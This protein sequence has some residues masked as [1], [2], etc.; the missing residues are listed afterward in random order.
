[1]LFLDFIR[2]VTIGELQAV[3]RE[4][5]LAPA[6]ARSASDVGASR[7]NE[8]EFFFTEIAHYLYAGDTALHMAAAA[9]RRDV[10]ELLIAHDAD[11]RAKNR[12]GAEPLHYAVDTNRWKPEAQVETILYLLMAGADPNATDMDGVTPLHRAVRTRSAPAVQALLE[13]GANPTRRNKRGST[14]MQVA[15]KMTGRS[16]SGTERAREQQAEIIRLLMAH[17]ESGGRTAR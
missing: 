10:I 16:G 2:L 12:R 8:S 6:L 7:S 17:G 11:C 1:M 4:L 14:P 9:F 3:S 15:T 5:T 13:G